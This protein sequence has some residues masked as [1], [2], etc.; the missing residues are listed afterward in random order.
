MP[1]ITT[2]PKT[3]SESPKGFCRLVLTEDNHSW[4]R[5]VETNDGGLEYR[6]GAGKFSEIDGRQ[7]RTL[8]R[9]I[10]QAAKS[11]QIASLAVDLKFSQ[12]PKLASETEV[13]FYATIAENA[14][15]SAYEYTAYKTKEDKRV[16]FGSLLLCSVTSA[17]SKK[18]LAHGTIVATFANKARDLANTPGCDMTPTDLANAA[19]ILFSKTKVG[20]SVLG[21]KEIKKLNM[22]ALLAVGQGTKSETKF[23]VAEYWGA[24]KSVGKKVSADKKPIVLIGKGVT[25][26]TGGLNVK[27]SGAMHDM[28]LDMSGGAAVLAAIGA[29]AALGLKKNVV[30]LVPAAENSVSAEAM[31]AGDIVTAMNGM[32]IEVLH[33]D[34]E[35]RMIV[36]DAFTYSERYSPSV[37]LDVA[38]LTGAAIV[39]LGEHASATM[40]TDVKL[41]GMLSELGERT[42]D[43]VWPLPLWDEFKQHLKSTRADVTNIANNFSK[44]GVAIEGGTFLS[45][46]APK[47]IPWAHIDMAPRMES[48]ASDKL[49]KGATGEPVRLLV[50]FIEAWIPRA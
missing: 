46:F 33:T 3:L 17:E 22:G 21:E 38:T 14:L 24:G 42:G 10:V 36:A 29:A 7:F 26:D 28:H 49:A 4:H 25:Y 27:P 16:A 20:L 41:S 6:L 47:D 48:I 15:L 13:W 5:L 9:T 31:R 32:T 2:T 45:Y 1:T 8:V 34:A 19:R 43:L 39:A 18:A 50:A 23:I 30:A 12:F 40:T 35:G 11:H 37:V 44:W